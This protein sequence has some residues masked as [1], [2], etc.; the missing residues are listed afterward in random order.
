MADAGSGTRFAAV[1][2]GMTRVWDVRSGDEVAQ[3]LDEDIA[4]TSFSRDGAFL[5][6]ADGQE[7][8]VWRLSDPETPSSAAPSTTSTCPAAR[9]GT[10]TVPSRATSKAAPSTPSMSRAP[11][12]PR[13]RTGPWT[14][15]GSAPT[16]ARS[17]TA[18]PH[19]AR[20]PRPGL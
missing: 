1:T 15:Y 14:T 6:T 2:P 16:A 10:R 18:S 4:W 19:P 12:P 7:L 11:S 20:T 17:R 8:R 9:P 13:G 3:I 5:A